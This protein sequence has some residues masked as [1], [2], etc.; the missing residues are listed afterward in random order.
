MTFLADSR[1]DRRL[2]DFNI[3]GLKDVLQSR[4]L[5]REKMA[6]KNLSVNL[7]CLT[8]KRN[9]L[10]IDIRAFALGKA[11]CNIGDTASTRCYWA[12]VYCYMFKGQN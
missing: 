11:N 8:T 3:S 12:M 6:A 2:L 10:L 7:H 5:P 9:M 1:E 4:L